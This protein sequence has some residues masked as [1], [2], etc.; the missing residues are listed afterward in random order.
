MKVKFV[1]LIKERIQ[2]MC[3][4]SPYKKY[5]VNMLKP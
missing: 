5:V 3:S 1:K 4:K 2:F